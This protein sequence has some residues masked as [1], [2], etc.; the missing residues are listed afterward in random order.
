MKKPVT[1]KYKGVD[2]SHLKL[3]EIH[4]LL[5]KE[6]PNISMMTVM[7]AERVLKLRPAWVGYYLYS[8]EQAEEMAALIRFAD[9]EYR[10]GF[11]VF[12]DP[13]E[14]MEILLNGRG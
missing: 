8:A 1:I 2:R 3:G 5:D 6:F 14:T 4:G 13:K 7:L 9:T 10:F 12:S 11:L